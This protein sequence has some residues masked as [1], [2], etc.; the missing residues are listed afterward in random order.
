MDPIVA[1]QDKKKKKRIIIIVLILLLLLLLLISF[2]VL[3]KKEYEITFDTNGGSEI[4]SVK[5]K[6][7]DKIQAPEDPTKEGYVFAGWYYQDELYDFNTPV[8]CD[9]TL[10]A[11]W[12]EDG[13]AEVEGVELNATQLSIAPDGTAELIATLLPENA[14]YVKLIWSSS[15]E[16]IAT[17]DENGNIKAL[18]EGTVTVTVTTEDGKYTASC[19][20]KI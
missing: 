12:F 3:H 20:V 1:E 15:D 11:E 13:D 6:E 5:V 17:V 10:K 7:N 9:M 8:K 2:L 18:R 14:K 19:T 4:A 16:S